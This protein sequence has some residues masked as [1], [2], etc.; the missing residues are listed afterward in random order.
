MVSTSSIE[1]DTRE[2]D[3]EFK[4]IKKLLSPPARRTILEHMA[5][6]VAIVGA[7]V[8]KPV[9][10]PPSGK[11]LAQFYSRVVTAKK[12]YK[13]ASGELRVPGGTYKSKFKSAKQQGY[14]LALMR[15]GRKK[16]KG[17][18]KS[19]SGKKY[20]RTGM[21]GRSINGE[22][23]KVTEKS[24]DVMIGSNLKY[25]PF[26][27]DETEQSNYHK[28]TWPIIQQQLRRGMYDI[29]EAA[30]KAFIKKAKE[31]LK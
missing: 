1:V 28:G 16:G 4:R 12:P 5:E 27:I 25:A 31:M 19:L 11:P 10:P 7:G 29:N 20:R 14:V 2:V 26:V 13:T 18:G 8:G 24:A 22:V 23:I 21:L 15:G 17:K 9:Y 30:L 3:A 6:R